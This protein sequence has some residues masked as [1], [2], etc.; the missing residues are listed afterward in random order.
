[1]KDSWRELAFP[2]VVLAVVLVF[3]FAVAVSAK[4]VEFPVASENCGSLGNVTAAAQHARNEGMPLEEAL[5]EFQ[6]ASDACVAENGADKCILQDKVGKDML[7]EM[8][9]IIW[10][11]PPQ[12]PTDFGF[13]VYQECLRANKGKSL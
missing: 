10:K 4:T 12:D 1:M 7:E 11:N 5:K 2:S 9:R 3:C 13:T 6:L 8:M